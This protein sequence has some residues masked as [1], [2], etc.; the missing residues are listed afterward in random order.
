MGIGQTALQLGRGLRS[1]AQICSHQLRLGGG[2]P[3]LRVVRFCARLMIPAQRKSRWR[4]VPH[5]LQPAEMPAKERGEIAGKD[6]HRER[7]LGGEELLTAQPRQTEAVAQF[8]DDALDAGASLVVAPDFQCADTL[9]Q[10][11]SAV[12]G[13]CSRGIPKASCRRRARPPRA[14]AGGPGDAGARRSRFRKGGR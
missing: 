5:S 4:R 8:L 9:R 11:G 13:I 12:P 2:K 3:S 7:R 14:A 6:A 1:L 10:V